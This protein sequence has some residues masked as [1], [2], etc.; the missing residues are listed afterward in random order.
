[1]SQKFGGF[2]LDSNLTKDNEIPFNVN[3]ND[4]ASLPNAPKS[5][6]N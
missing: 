4:G 2:K 3:F 1:V 5:Q 6:L